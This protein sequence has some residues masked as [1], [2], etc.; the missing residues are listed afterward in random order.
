MRRLVT[1][2]DGDGRSCVVQDDVVV[3]ADAPPPGGVAYGL[4][5]TSAELPPPL[6]APGP[7]KKLDLGVQRGLG[8]M[9]VRW[10]P[11]FEWPPHH[12]DS[13]DFDIVLDGSI[14]LVLDDGA[15]PLG[16]GDAVLVTGTDHAWRSGPE[17]CT[18]AIVAIGSPRD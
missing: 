13:I 6:S 7:A 5:H 1:G 8:W 11:G 4:L 18:M 3:L 14:E 17:G 16:P 15:H 12:T 9:V 2:T 10:D